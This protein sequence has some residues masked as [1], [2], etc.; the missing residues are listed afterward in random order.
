MKSYRRLLRNHGINEN[1]LTIFH[2]PATWYSKK[3]PGIEST[4]PEKKQEFETRKEFEEG[5][6]KI[7]SS[8]NSYQVL[9]DETTLFVLEKKYE[10]NKEVKL[11]EEFKQIFPYLFP[12]PIK[13]GKEE[14]VIANIYNHFHNHSKLNHKPLKKAE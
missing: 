7:I 10:D 9:V 12:L 8:N 1:K 11:K 6:D 14:V 13:T 2:V 4:S 3:T 5:L